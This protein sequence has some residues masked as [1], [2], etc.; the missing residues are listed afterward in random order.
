MRETKTHITERSA[1]AILMSWMREIIE[2]HKLDIGLPIV[3]TAGKDNKFPDMEIYASRR[4]EDCLCLFEAKRPNFDVFEHEEELKEPARKKAT[5]RNAK[6]FVLLNFRKLVWFDTAKVNAM[7]PEEQQIIATYTLSD[8][9]NLDDLETTRNAARIKKNL[10]DFLLKLYNVHTGKEAISQIPVD[11]L[12]I[13]KLQEK[14]NLLTHYY[15]QIIED[16]CGEDADFLQNLHKWF[17]DQSWNFAGTFDDFEKA[18]RQA[19]YLLVNKIL[20]YDTLQNK[21]PNDLDKL[22][23]P[24]SLTKGSSLQTHLQ[25]YFNEALKIDYE[26]VFSVDFV[27][28]LAFPD[29]REVVEEIKKL[30]SLL[31]RYNLSELGFDIIGRIFERLIPSE[32]RHNFGQYFTNSDVVDLILKFCLKHEKDKTLDPSCGSGTFLVRAYQHKKLMN[33]RQT[34]EEILDTIWGNDIAKF[35]ASLSIINLAINDLSVNQN[36]PNI[37]HE[38]FF[39]I[40][41]DADGVDLEAWKGRMAKTLSGQERT[42]DYPKQFDAIVGNPPYT[43][44]EEIS[45]LAPEDVEYKENLIESAVKVGGKKIAELSKRAGIHAFFFVHGWKF[46]REGGRFGFIVSNSWLD[47]DYGRGLQEFFLKHFKITAIIESKIERWFAEADVN[48]CIVI[49]EKCGN[50]AE[51][52]QN[53]TRFVYLKKNLRE[54]IPPTSDQKDEEIKRHHAIEDFCDTV[55]THRKIYEN[56][57]FR[58]YPI[59]QSELYEEG[60]DAE[61]QKFIGA[62]WGKYLRASEV[63]FEILRKCK[64]KFVPLRDLAK[65][66]FG[67]KTGANEFFYLTQADVKKHEIEKRFLQPIIFS[68]KEVKGY[69]LDKKSLRN[70]VIICHKPKS[71]IKDT[72]LLKYLEKGEKQGFSKR[73][74][75][76]QRGEDSWYVLAKNWDYAPL[77]FPSKVGERMPVFLND[78]IFEDKKLYGI[79]PKENVDKLFLCAIL[80]STLA[81]M[82][83][84]FTCRQLTG[85]QAIADIDVIVVKSLLVPKLEIV[86]DTVKEE[87]KNAFAQLLKN[88]AESVFKEIAPSPEEVSFEKVRPDRLE[89]DRIVLQEILGLSEKEHLEVYKAVVDLVK[90]RLEKA[91]SVGKKS[92]KSEASLGVAFADNFYEDL[93]NGD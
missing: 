28:E 6:Y 51:R 68:L 13:N 9:T 90:S 31:N 2:T 23:I 11:E 44:Q 61:E 37:L 60:F 64:D 17:Y 92:R 57:D 41:L 67:I 86:S 72:N 46:L 81:R 91:K 45:E 50:Q 22:E 16:K 83:I 3:E 79:T 12:L 56:D 40:K 42:L 66:R 27:D 54:F 76:K 43:R 78:K 33:K 20:F 36:Y 88:N 59:L 85:S 47:T 21:R 49:L 10:E 15:S 24:A 29:S 84:E 48:T 7:L 55:L 63:F 34:H 35:P 8:L 52:E 71:K 1:V 39:N 89:L 38:D 70:Q 26:S 4:S 93:K 58:I 69:R 14:I 25:I 87:L 82:F 75:C 73:S 5:H 62:K 32:E 77:I 19:S 30:I 80:N 65:V 74:T 53:L 18:A